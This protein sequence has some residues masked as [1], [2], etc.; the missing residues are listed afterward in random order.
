MSTL[1]QCTV[2]RGTHKGV[3]FEI[4]SR[5]PYDAEKRSLDWTFYVIF[6]ES[7]CADFASIWLPEVIHKMATRDYVSN[8][9]MGS[10]LANVE[11]HCDIT[12]YE[13]VGHAEGHRAVKAGCDYQHYWDEGH[14]YDLADL[15]RDAHR[16]IESAFELGILKLQD[17]AKEKAA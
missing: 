9:Y 14:F 2:Y 1:R 17:H 5:K 11:W 6:C 7:Q 15:E 16:A 13:K 4:N 3:P 10:R 12:F 8:D